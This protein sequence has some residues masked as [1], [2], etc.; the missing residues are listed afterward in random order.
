MPLAA[1]ALALPATAHADLGEYVKAR[2][3]SAD[4]AVDVAAAGYAAA[5]A[6]APGDEVVAIRAYRNALAAGD[7]ALARRAA[8][9]LVRS[10]ERD[11]PRR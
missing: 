2:A 5:L 7:I 1:L 4:G 6:A 3:A 8:A 9:V 10:G 11:I